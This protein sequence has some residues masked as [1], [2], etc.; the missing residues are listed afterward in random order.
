MLPL[1]PIK[2]PFGLQCTIGKKVWNFSVNPCSSNEPSWAMP[3]NISEFWLRPLYNNSLIY[4]YLPW[5]SIRSP[6]DFLYK[7]IT[8]FKFK[9][10]KKKKTITIFYYYFFF[11]KY[12]FKDWN[13]RPSNLK[14]FKFI[15]KDNI[16]INYVFVS[17]PFPLNS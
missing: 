7:A 17:E 12:C 6:K 14:Y 5:W 8:I 13:F 4:F 15:R 1:S 10:K 9:G 3:K 16:Y 11:Q 2:S